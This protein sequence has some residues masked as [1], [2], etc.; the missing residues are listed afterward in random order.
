[1]ARPRKKKLSI[2]SNSSHG[3]EDKEDGKT[4]DVKN[5]ESKSK[6]KKM[7]KCQGFEDCHMAFTRA[8]HLARHIRKHTGE[9][10]FQCYI[11]LK[12]F[13]RVDNLKQH[14]ESVHSKMEYSSNFSEKDPRSPLNHSMNTGLK[15]IQFIKEK[16]PVIISAVNYAGNSSKNGNTSALNKRI[17][18]TRA[19]SA[20]LHFQSFKPKAYT[21][22]AQG[23]TQGKE[24]FT[25]LPNDHTAPTYGSRHNSI[26][27]ELPTALTNTNNHGPLPTNGPQD[28]HKTDYS[29]RMNEPNT[30]TALP[31]RIQEQNSL[32]L[33]NLYQQI[34]SKTSP[35]PPPPPTLSMPGATSKAPPPFNEMKIMPRDSALRTGSISEKDTVSPF[36]FGQQPISPLH[37]SFSQASPP[38]TTTT[39]NNNNNNNIPNTDHR[40]T[41]EAPESLSDHRDGT[42]GSALP[43]KE[44]KNKHKRT[45]SNERL[46]LDFIMS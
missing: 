22:D 7:F 9:K 1:M 6:C 25:K 34:I 28:L 23:A 45:R 43:V 29:W 13:S 11:C 37:S 16:S 40:G 19:N 14:R 4:S 39:T 10:P 35:R 44:Q 5:G 42:S 3:L 2:P 15:E 18:P 46:S 12:H 41:E 21:S 26:S 17:K 38:L 20:E 30:I 27:G 36:V 32:P 31:M 24:H 8:E 33:P